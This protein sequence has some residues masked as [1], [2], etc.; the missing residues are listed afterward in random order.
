MSLFRKIAFVG[1]ASLF[2][3][4]LGCGP[5]LEAMH[6]STLRFEHCYRLDMDMSIAPPHREPCW[7][8]WTETYAGGQPL[9]RIEYARRRISQLESGDTRLLGIGEAARSETRVFEELS[10]SPPQAPIAAPA[11]TSAHEPPPKTVQVTKDGPAAK[12]VAPSDSAKASSLRPGEACSARCAATLDDCNSRPEH[13]C[14]R[15]QTDCV[16][17]DEEYRGCMRRCFE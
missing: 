3:A 4:G 14:N 16:A 17:C 1:P 5:G 7:R 6:E 9:D 10:S 8:D 11:P 13:A 2:A 15:K 12:D